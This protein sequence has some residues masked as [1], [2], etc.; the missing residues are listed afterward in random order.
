MER[1][2]TRAYRKS[3]GSLVDRILP[4]LI[5]KAYFRAVPQNSL[6]LRVEVT[7][8]QQR[9]WPAAKRAVHNLLAR[10]H[11]KEARSATC[12]YQMSGLG[13][14][15]QELDG[16]FQLFPPDAICAGA[17]TDVPRTSTSRSRWKRLSP[18][19]VEPCSSLSN[20]HQRR[21]RFLLSNSPL[22]W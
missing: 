1:D 11:G 17:Y 21:T 8:M 13:T 19:N 3:L 5:V 2:Y 9:C 22:L 4:V 16:L 10:R 12:A 20:H 6:C 15:R 18:E 14:G 7:Q